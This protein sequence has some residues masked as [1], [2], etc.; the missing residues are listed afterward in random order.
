M[1]IRKRNRA[2]EQSLTIVS[3]ESDFSI[4]RTRNN[5]RLSAM[6]VGP[7]AAA[8]MSFKEVLDLNN[9]Q[10]WKNKSIVNATK[11]K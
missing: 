5:E 7:V 11:M 1:I 8:G 4:I 3:P 9:Q 10:Q 6:E 2:K